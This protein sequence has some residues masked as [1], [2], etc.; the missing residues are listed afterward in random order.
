[1]SLRALHRLSCKFI[2][3]SQCGC[4]VP[5]QASVLRASYCTIVSAARRPAVE[6]VAPMGALGSWRSLSQ[7]SLAWRRVTASEQC[8]PPPR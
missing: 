2:S 8:R 3:A 1:M 4:D 6:S 5:I 7:T